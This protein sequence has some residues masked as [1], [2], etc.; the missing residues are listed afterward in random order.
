MHISD[1]TR[2]LRNSDEYKNL[3]NSI[4]KTKSNIQI[5][6]ID[7][8]IPFLSST[9][10]SDLQ[11]PTL[12]ICPSAYHSIN[13]QENLSAWTSSEILRF[14]EVENLPY[15]RI[16]TD[17][18]TAINRIETISKISNS[19]KIPL[20][21][22]SIS[23]ICQLT[24]ESS[25]LHK[26]SKRMFKD[27]KTTMEEI[28]RF[29]Q[30]TGYEFDTTVTTQGTFS[31]RG[32][33]LDIFPV[34]SNNPYR[35]EFWGNEIDSIRSFDPE[36]QRSINEVPEFELFPATEILPS[37]LNISQLE[38]QISHIDLQNCD[39]ENSER[40][41]NDLNDL[42]NKETID[43][44]SLYQGFFSNGSLIDFMPQNSLIILYRPADIFNNYWEIEERILQLKQNKENQ[45]H[46]PYN[47][48]ISHQSLNKI[49]KQIS[50]K[51][52]K[53]EMIPWGSET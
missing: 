8:S 43:D 3:F 51:N 47:F 49:E 23:A 28:C 38:N 7:E 50:D 4:N 21:V 31:R 32:G 33:I 27:Q 11:K 20:V 48:P 5:Q 29:L 45:G 26:S 42:M 35:L 46:I 6:T 12:I 40:I 39:P 34:G 15:E 22:T 13:L 36:T 53:I 2:F 18:E 24:I 52:H 25:V 9:L 30:Q 37:F 16:E 1:F 17:R 10:A 41:N 19:N 44:I 14:P